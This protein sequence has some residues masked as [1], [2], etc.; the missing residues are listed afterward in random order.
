[1]TT[2]VGIAAIVLGLICWI[3]QTL[4]V[5]NNGLATKLGLSETEKE[6][7]STMLVFERYSQGIMD[8]VLA[9][10][11]PLA[12]FLMIIENK[13]WPVFALVGG[14]VYLYFPG[15]FI[16]TRIVLKKRGLKIGTRNGEIT[17]YIFGILWTFIALIM[18]ALAVQCVSL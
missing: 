4:A 14:G 3:G 9:W 2:I 6:M 7:D 1:M 11:L 5:F 12:G 13:W 8:V 17:A 16:I 10:I 18:I 15:Q